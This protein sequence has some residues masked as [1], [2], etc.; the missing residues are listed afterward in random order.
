MLKAS[1]AAEQ[2]CWV[3]ALQKY[4]RDIRLYEQAKLEENVR[5]REAEVDVI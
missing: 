1:S 5:L 4:S 3:E 2:A